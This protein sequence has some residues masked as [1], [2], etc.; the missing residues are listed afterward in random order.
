MVDYLP[1]LLARSPFS[2][3]IETFVDSRTLEHY[4]LRF[5]SKP[6]QRV[7]LLGASNIAIHFV[8]V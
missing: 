6:E 5:Y 8:G 4:E 2:S 7:D 3:L 1:L